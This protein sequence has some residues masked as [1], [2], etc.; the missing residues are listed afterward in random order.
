MMGTD[1]SCDSDDANLRDLHDRL[2]RVTDETEIR[3]LV[4]EIYLL[5][6]HAPDLSDYARLFTS[7]AVWERV[8]GGSPGS[9][10]GTRL[11]GIEAI[12]ADRQHLRA[13]GRAGPDSTIRHLLTTVA[14]TVLDENSARAQSK[15]L[16]VKGIKPRPVIEAV[17]HYDDTLRH[18]DQGW[19]VSH[20]RF[21]SLSAN[22]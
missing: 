19:R 17:G 7:D 18:T 13:N 21:S 8:G 9:H 5:S 6:D 11:A 10:L 12:I 14:V 15:F 2:R 4:A 22:R 20:R 1:H 3:N 16:V